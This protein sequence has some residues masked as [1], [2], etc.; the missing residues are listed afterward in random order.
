MTSQDYDLVLD[1]PSGP[2]IYFRA[3]VPFAMNTDIVVDLPE[4]QMTNVTAVPALPIPVFS[5]DFSNWTNVL[6]SARL[7]KVIVSYRPA[8]TMGVTNVYP[9]VP[10]ASTFAAQDAVLMTVP[11]YEN[12]D[13]IVDETGALQVDATSA[14]YAANKMRPYSRIHSIY[15]PWKRIMK[16]NLTQLTDAYG[17][18]SSTT[19][20]IQKSYSGYVDLSTAA[21]G[22]M[23]YNGMLFFMPAIRPGGERLGPEPVPVF[24]Q[25]GRKFVLGKLTFTFVLALKSSQ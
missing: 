14:Q 19:T 2:N 11:I 20:D 22:G 13:R 15:K 17:T 4:L 5:Q 16:P 24:P 10:G 3:Y 1:N 12:P 8:Q 7:A 25:T 9:G 18:S 6:S 23:T 21:A